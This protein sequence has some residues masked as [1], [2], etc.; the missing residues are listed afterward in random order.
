MRSPRQPAAILLARALS[1]VQFSKICSSGEFPEHI[2][3]RRLAP[4]RFCFS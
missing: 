4:K 3:D 1:F 2:V